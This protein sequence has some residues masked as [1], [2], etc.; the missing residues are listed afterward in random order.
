M[1]VKLFFVCLWT[2]LLF[3]SVFL[4]VSHILYDQLDE[5]NILFY[6]ILLEVSKCH[7]GRSCVV[8][9]CAGGKPIN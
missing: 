4:D 2:V 9:V 6:S 3:L 5:I 1:F 8:K 7:G